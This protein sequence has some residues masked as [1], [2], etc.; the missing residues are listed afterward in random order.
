M[1]P[2]LNKCLRPFQIWDIFYV[3]ESTSGSLESSCEKSHV[4]S[5]ERFLLEF[6]LTTL[7]DWFKKLAPF[8]IQSEVKLKPIMTRSHTLSRAFCR[9]HVFVLS[10]DWFA[11]LS[12]PFVIGQGNYLGFRWFEELSFCRFPTLN[13]SI[14]GR[15]SNLVHFLF[16]Y[17]RFQTN[18]KQPFPSQSSHIFL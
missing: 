5:L 3:S 13:T 11:L 1:C 10:F 6:A 8:F 4:R 9:L 14:L 2:S 15:L 16:E 17:L 7:R 12:V 18:G